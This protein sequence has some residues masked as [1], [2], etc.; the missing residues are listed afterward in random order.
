MFKGF[1]LKINDADKLMLK[2]NFY[3]IGKE[4]LEKD[5]TNMMNELKKYIGINGAIDC[6]KLQKD[7]FPIFKNHIFLS[8]SH[9][10]E[11]LAISFAGWLYKKFGLKTFIDSCVWGYCDDLLYSIDKEYCKNK[12][13]GYFNYYKRNISTSHVHMMLASSLN[14][15]IDS[16]ECIMFLNT[17]KSILKTNEIL[18]TKTQ[19][20]WIYEEILTTALI[21]K[22][23]PKRFLEVKKS[24][25]TKEI[26]NEVAEL[27][28]EYDV[29]LTH[30]IKLEFEE[31]QRIKDVLSSKNIYNQVNLNPEESL[32][33]LYCSKGI[34]DNSKHIKN[35]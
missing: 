11:E 21:R 6:T 23:I 28:C 34:I 18:S 10:D 22:N 33:I 12:E 17:D 24:F 9:A 3:N 1:N 16:T 14:N 31:L 13:D 5:K 29:D 25:N 19:S 2:K 15:M 7:W 20:A 30:L 32:D 26:L 8:H 4:N 35:I 27:K